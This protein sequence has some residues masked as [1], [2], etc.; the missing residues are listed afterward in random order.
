[1]ILCGCFLLVATCGG[2]GVLGHTQTNLN[3][4][5]I[6]GLKQALLFPFYREVW[7]RSLFSGEGAL[8]DWL[9]SKSLEIPILESESTV[10]EHANECVDL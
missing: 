9:P 1:M 6:A 4:P 7:R 3:F 2:K 5:I 8:C 10:P